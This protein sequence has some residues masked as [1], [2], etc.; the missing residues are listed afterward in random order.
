MFLLTEEQRQKVHTETLDKHG[1]CSFAV[2]QEALAKAQLK[3]VVE[4]C[5]EKGIIDSFCDWC[6]EDDKCEICEDLHQLRKEA[7]IDE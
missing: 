6:D 3:Y 7:G 2:L 1:A 4:V 5:L